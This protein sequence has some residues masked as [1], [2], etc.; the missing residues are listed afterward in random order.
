MQLPPAVRRQLGSVQSSSADGRGL[1]AA[2]LSQ[3]LESYLLVRCGCNVPYWSRETQGSTPW[4][5]TG[6][7]Q[8][9]MG[10]VWVVF[11]EA[12]EPRGVGIRIAGRRNIHTLFLIAYV[13]RSGEV[14][15]GYWYRDGVTGWQHV[16]K[17]D[18][19]GNKE[20]HLNS[21]R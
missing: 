10:M 5:P 21:P 13:R 17:R 15:S 9:Y 14:E 3:H 2:Q 8:E 18:L 16:P 20:C 19:G 6:V 12:H 11:R 7:P 1:D 4:G